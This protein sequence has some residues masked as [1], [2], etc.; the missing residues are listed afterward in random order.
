[1]SYRCFDV[2]SANV[3]PVCPTYMSSCFL[4]LAAYITPRDLQLPDF[5]TLT[6]VSFLDFLLTKYSFFPISR[7]VLQVLFFAIDGGF[8]EIPFSNAIFDDEIC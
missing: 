5:T 6:D 4:H 1:M 2:R 8:I 3:S 7:H